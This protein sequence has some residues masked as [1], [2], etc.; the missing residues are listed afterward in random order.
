MKG[1]PRGT[2]DI[3]S[4]PRG[5]GTLAVDVAGRIE[6]RFIPAR[7]GNTTGLPVNPRPIPVHPRAGGEHETWF[8]WYVPGYGSSPR[9]RGTHR[10]DSIRVAIR[11]FIPARAGNTGRRCS[12]AG[13]STVHPRAGGEHSGIIHHARKLDGSSPR[14]RGTR[15]GHAGEGRHRRFIPARAG[16]TARYR[17]TTP[18]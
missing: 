16:N 2:H 17:R 12:R 3:G 7:A 18:S 4:S 1:G 6:M 11:R 10:W 8:K 9:G 15:C 5:R 14:G 13:G